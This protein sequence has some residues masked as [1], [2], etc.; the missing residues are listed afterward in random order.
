MLCVFVQR[1][2]VSLYSHVYLQ[3]VYVYVCVVCILLCVRWCVTVT[4]GSSLQSI[5]RLVAALCGR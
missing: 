1:P 2:P 5:T 4:N 3:Y